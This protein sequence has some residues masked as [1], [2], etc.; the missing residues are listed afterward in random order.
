MNQSTNNINRNREIN[1]DKVQLIDS[2]CHL[3]FDVFNSDRQIV[4]YACATNGISDLVI[5]GV[6]AE[7]WDSLLVMCQ[8]ESIDKLQ[9]SDVRL[10]PAIGL[11]PLFIQ[12]H[13]EEHLQDLDL[14]LSN[15]KVVAIGEIGLDFFDVKDKHASN[16]GKQ[17][18]FFEEQLKLAKKYELPVI[19][20]SR[21][22]H[23]QILSL[24]KIHKIQS[25]GIAHAFNGSIQQA[26]Q[27]ISLGFKLGFGGML[28]F[29]RSTKLRTLA[30]Q[31]PLESIVLETDSPDM[32]VVQHRGERNS[33]EYLPYVLEALAD[34]RDESMQ[35]IAAQ[36]TMNVKTL[37]KL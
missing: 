9:N 8:G 12:H 19:L 6:L 33:P 5:P 15:H 7:T 31:L 37:L 25:G 20:H 34:I 3:D 17:S 16:E 24:L 23:D 26:Q 35:L 4:L 18:F 30:K 27:Y 32:T 21:K 28:T 36:T 1:S 29:E 11:H 2:H 13:K 14:Y 10:H 22:S